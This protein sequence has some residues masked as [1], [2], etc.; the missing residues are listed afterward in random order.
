MSHVS[1]RLALFALCLPPL[2]PAPADSIAW[3]PKP[4]AALA[5]AKEQNL[6][7]FV[8]INF[9]GERACDRFAEKAY[10]DKS[11]VALSASAVCVIASPSEHGG[12]AKPCPRFGSL[13]CAEHKQTDIWARKS[14]LKPDA[15]GFVVAP[16]HVFLAPD[17]K[18]I[19][20]VPYEI[21]E[22]ELAWCFVTAI[23]SIDP[24]SKVV[25]PPG[26]HPPRRLNLG[27][28]IDP[29][30]ARAVTPATH[31]EVVALIKAIKKG[32]KGAEHVDALR[33]ILSSDE[34]EG[35]DYIKT[36]LRSGTG[37]GGGSGGGSVGL[38]GGGGGGGGTGIPSTG[39]GGGGGG[40]GEDNRAL[41]LHTIG[42]LSPASYW[43]VVADFA[44]GGEIGLRSEAAVALEE[45]AAPASL[46]KVQAALA[47]ESHRELKKDWIRALGAAGAADAQVRKELLKRA[48]SEKDELLR[49][50]TLIALGSLVPG[51]DVSEVL[52]SV[53]KSG[54]AAERSAVVCALAIS[55]DPKWIEAI[56]ATLKEATDADLVQACNMA[57]H[58]LRSGGL[59][60]IREVLTKLAQDKIERDRWYGRVPE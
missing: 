60:P 7:L 50:N 40:G 22:S 26:A 4:E 38:G 15:E 59:A 28:I 57:A 6:P 55:R 37:G 12:G 32:L 5:R 2:A 53:L 47:K 27:A 16:Q 25:A 18:V 46:K 23:H 20:S 10:H 58:S 35:V 48:R 44:L 24:K 8:A 30:S 17:G 41:I 1:A 31:E 19:L 43:E 52:S 42:A 56:D 9:D 33:R 13:L 51:D 3:E 54:S 34:P 29:V 21:G 49:L 45:L 39:G 14:V 36:E 11:I